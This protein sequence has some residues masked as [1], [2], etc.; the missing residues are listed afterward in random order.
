MPRSAAEARV[1]EFATRCEGAA[2]PALARSGAAVALTDREIDIASLAAK[3]LLS[4]EIAEQLFLSRRTVDNYLQR[5]YVKL[6][7]TDRSDLAEAL[8]GVLP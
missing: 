4:R 6:G 8:E 1:R 3:G 5:V 7:I 2:T